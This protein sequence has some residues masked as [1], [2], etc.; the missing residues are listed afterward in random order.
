MKHRGFK[1]ITSVFVAA[2]LLAVAS[3]FTIPTQAAIKS[4]PVEFL[5][6]DTNLAVVEG[7][8]TEVIIKLPSGGTHA[9]STPPFAV[10]HNG[11]AVGADKITYANPVGAQ[12]YGR[13]TAQSGAAVG[14][15]ETAYTIKGRFYA[16]IAEG[17]ALEKWPAK[18]G[19]SPGMIEEVVI[20]EAGSGTFTDI[21]GTES[22]GITVDST[23]GIR[24]I[25]DEILGNPNS[26]NFEIIPRGSGETPGTGN[27]SIYDKVSTNGVSTKN[28]KKVV[29]ITLY[30]NSGARLNLDLYPKQT[31][32]GWTGRWTEIDNPLDPGNPTYEPELD[33]KRADLIFAGST[34]N[35]TFAMPTSNDLIL[36][37]VTA[38]M[39]TNEIAKNV[40][41]LATAKDYVKLVA[42]DD[43]NWITNNFSLV[44]KAYI[45]G[46]EATI[47]W[48]WDGLQAALEIGA[49]EG[50]NPIGAKITPQVDDVQGHLKA[51]V[52]YGNEIVGNTEATKAKTSIIP[53][54]ITIRGKGKAPYVKIKN[55]IINGVID[56][57][58]ASDD[59]R[60]LPNEMD[61]FD[62][63]ITGQ[64][65]KPPTQPNIT[66]STV[67]MGEKNAAAEYMII[68]SSDPSAVDIFLDT[69]LMPYIF[70]EKIMN[71]NQRGTGSADMSI[72]AKTGG[73]STT[74]TF[75]FYAKQKTQTAELY[76]TLSANP[77]S[78]YDTTPSKNAELRAITMKSKELPVGYPLDV[79][80]TEGKYIYAVEVPYAA[81]TLEVN[82]AEDDPKAKFVVTL[83]GKNKDDPLLAPDK[84]HERT[85]S[86][87]KEIGTGVTRVIKIDVT[88]QDPTSKRPYTLNITRASASRD[89]SLKTLKVFSEESSDAKDLLGIVGTPSSTKK[90]ELHVPYGI[91]RVRVDAE[92]T[93]RWVRSISIIPSPVRNMFFS[94]TEWIKLGHKDDK[95]NPSANPTPIEITVLPEDTADTIG[96]KYGVDVTRDNPSEN[97]MLKSLELSDNKGNAMPFKVGATEQKFLKTQRDYY[98][99]INYST[100]QIRLKAQPEHEYATGVTLVMPDGKTETKKYD[101]KKD[102]PIEFRDISI[103][104]LSY[105]KTF[106]IQ[107]YA[108]AESGRPTSA[109]EA[110]GTAPDTTAYYLYTIEITRNPADSDTRLESLKL[111]DQDGKAVDAFSFNAEKL[112]YDVTVPYVTSAVQVAPKPKSPISFAT[113]NNLPITEQRPFIDLP[114]TA[115]KKSVA[116]VI[117]EAENGDKR[118]YTINIT[119]SMP[120]TE[121]RLDLL[122]VPEGTDFAPRWVPAN[123][124]YTVK[125]KEGTKSYTVIAKPV[126]EYATIEIN[127]KAAVSNVAFGPITSVQESSKVTIKVTAQDGKTSKVYTI[128]VTDEN[129]IIKGDNPDL[130]SLRIENGEMSPRFRAGIQDYEVYLKP[131][132]DWINV[133]P[134]PIDR[135]SKLEVFSGSKKLGDYYSDYSTAIVDDTTEIIITVTAP[136]SVKKT[137]NVT[138]L[139]NNDE[140][141]GKLKPITADMVNFEQASPIIVDISKYYVVAAEVINQMIEHPDKTIIFKGND[142]S[143]EMRGKDLKELVPNTALF[144]L[145]LSF[146]TPY[147]D[148][149][150]DLMEE[151]SRNDDLEPVFV[152]F[153]HHGKLPAPFKFT[154][155]LGREYQNRS[156]YWNYF[157]EERDRIDYYGTVRTNVKGTF[158]AMMTHMSDYL[159][160]KRRI[161]GSENKEGEAT[162]FSYGIST[163]MDEPK[164]NPNTGRV[165]MK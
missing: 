138:V 44:T 66:N 15:L 82:F 143:F 117:I 158:T 121:A 146:S 70:G 85:I 5:G 96:T 62:G 56:E 94:K 83:D 109:A 108:T 147:E 18:K 14:G 63:A 102:T 130:A 164:T 136:S 47:T 149:I 134:K 75:E 107:V 43:F 51:V 4:V 153:N 91:K 3:P 127:G 46:A 16:T 64:D 55:Q 13:F 116:T 150:W 11:V 33:P 95:D 79:G 89:S 141:Q 60:N 101:G 110:G 160:T 140:K 19:K 123:T 57:S 34:Y 139:R 122:S 24:A 23:I 68:K 112:E 119:R 162:S 9:S 12:R 2:V 159:I 41:D 39:V 154:L 50:Q 156:L 1:K 20:E 137:Y 36:R 32:L 84:I 71:P 65:I 90:Y 126:D 93:S 120:S 155:S 61:V 161:I 29:N 73:K 67:Y 40:G 22:S 88:A 42:G 151:E 27:L 111:I 25:N 157:N 72:R 100:E 6:G 152:H 35:I 99:N 7:I 49:Q 78:V 113:V 135:N 165:G 97:N 124:A 26:L 53:I 21:L 104:K 31:H 87:E 129:F 118:T 54:P 76:A 103:P 10:S 115:G 144:D 80:L 37:V 114:L 77:I 92:A 45:Y 125:L 86:I 142:Y 58:I 128:D 48:E 52:S 132:T 8:A 98:I 106:K 105:P 133:F 131:E 145:S 38:K 17:E 163:W 28:G 148:S 74:L 59:I 30:N 81:K 69:S